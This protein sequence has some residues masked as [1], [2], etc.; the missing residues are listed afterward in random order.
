MTM[1]LIDADKAKIIIWG[2]SR[3]S[4]ID[5]APYEYADEAIDIL[6]AVDAIPVAFIEEQMRRYE[7][8]AYN[9]I[10]KIQQRYFDKEAALK[11]LINNW[12]EKN[13][14]DENETR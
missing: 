5:E 4:G 10:P 1:R 7:E 3:F 13:G 8:L 6:P 14:E 2:Y 11:S 12:R 9:S